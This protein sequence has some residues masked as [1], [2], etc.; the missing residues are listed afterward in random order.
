MG[1]P[2]NNGGRRKGFQ[3]RSDPAAQANRLKATKPHS[4]LSA[5]RGRHSADCL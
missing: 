3:S 1:E 2:A 5:A 4:I